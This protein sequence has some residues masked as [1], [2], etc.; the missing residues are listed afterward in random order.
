MPAVHSFFDRLSTYLLLVVSM[1]EDRLVIQRITRKS[2]LF[3][4]HKR[5]TRQVEKEYSQ[6]QALE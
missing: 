5:P 1:R 2:R 4:Q 3:A 6:L